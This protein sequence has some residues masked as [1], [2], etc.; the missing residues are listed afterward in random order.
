[1]GA[2]PRVAAMD[3]GTDPRALIE[4]AEAHKQTG[5]AFFKEGNYQKAL[6]SYHKVFLYVNGVQV[7][8][9]K[10]EATAYANMMGKSTA[11]SQVPADKVEALK[12]L[13]QSTH[14]NMAACFLGVG[15]KS[16]TAAPEGAR[17]YKRCVE[18]CTKVI[19]EGPCTKAL[20]RRGQAHLELGNLDEAKADLTE[21]ERLEPEDVSIQRELRRIAHAFAQHDKREKKRFA[22]MFGKMEK[23]S[24]GEAPSAPA[25]GDS[26]ELVREAAPVDTVAAAAA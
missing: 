25:E 2:I 22:G 19:A 6:G 8:G 23:D 9:E 1:M 13:K 20:F 10:S 7:P 12:Q 11:S 4:Q 26:E 24:T 18:V 21:A 15:K 17:A 14:L 3:S 16:G 5:N